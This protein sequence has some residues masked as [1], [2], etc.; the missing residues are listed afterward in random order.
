MVV[1]KNSL[2]CELDAHIHRITFLIKLT[3]STADF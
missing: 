3:K 2:S 1:L